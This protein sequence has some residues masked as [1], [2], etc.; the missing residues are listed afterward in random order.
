MVADTDSE[1][2]AVDIAVAGT[3]VVGTVVADIAAPGI[4][5]LLYLYM[6]YSETVTAFPD[7]G[8][9]VADSCDIHIQSPLESACRN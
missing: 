6:D 4:H 8:Q 3:V 9:V 7:T 2:V 5:Y 1:T